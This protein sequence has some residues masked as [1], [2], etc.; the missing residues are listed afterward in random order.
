MRR[1]S[2]NYPIFGFLSSIIVFSIGQWIAKDSLV[3]YYIGIV[4]LTYLLFGYGA[5]LKKYGPFIIL[6]SL[7]MAL[8]SM[9][10]GGNYIRTWTRVVV[11][12]LASIPSLGINP[13]DLFRVLLKTGINAMIPIGVM[14]TMRSTTKM[15]DEMEKILKGRKLRGARGIRGLVRSIM[16]P[17]LIRIFSISDTMAISME[18]RGLNVKNKSSIYRVVVPGVKDYI[19]ILSVVLISVVGMLMY[20]GVL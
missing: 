18:T 17:A 15:K 8:T 12:G 2:S 7:V 10:L 16:I 11:F 3:Y 4:L 20:Y 14:V 1:Y 9:L 5:Q 6:L 13:A 19:Y